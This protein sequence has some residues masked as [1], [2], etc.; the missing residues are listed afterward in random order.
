VNESTGG[1]RHVDDRLIHRGAR[2]D[3][4]AATF[5]A[6]DGSRF[7]REIVRSAGAVAVVP[8]VS[9]A[10]VATVA[11]VS[12]YRPAHDRYLIEIPAGMRDVAGEAPMATARRELVEEVGLVAA[13]LSLLAECRVS[14]AMTDATT[15]VYL[16]TD[17]RPTPR[18]PEGPEEDHS[19]VLHVPLADALEWVRN[20]RID[21]AK[22]VIGLLLTDLAVQQCSSPH[23]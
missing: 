21:D 4:V 18:R 3:V 23:Q 10:A 5:D 19:E 15:T 8:L 2:W 16:A 6:P 1:F 7:E 9:G 14:A 13:D 12:Q 17:C 20:G 11:L 22:S